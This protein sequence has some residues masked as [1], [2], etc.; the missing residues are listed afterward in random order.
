VLL[1]LFIFL[2]WLI[3]QNVTEISSFI[4]L[5]IGIKCGEET[6]GSYKVHYSVILLYFFLGNFFAPQCFAI[7]VD[8]NQTALLVVNASE[9]SARPIP[10]TLFGIFFEVCLLNFNY[11]HPFQY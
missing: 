5:W 9:A 2:F 4:R 11:E 1:V 7:G 8:A 10:E 3:D 6:M